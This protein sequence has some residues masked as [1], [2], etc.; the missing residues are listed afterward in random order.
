MEAEVGIMMSAKDTPMVLF[1]KVIFWFIA[2]NALVGAM[3][4][5]LFPNRT[6]A[7]FFWEITPPIN[8]AL[9]GALYLGGAATVAWVTYRGLW[10][11]ARFLVPILVSAG[12]FI[13]DGGL[14]RGGPSLPL[15]TRS[16]QATRSREFLRGAL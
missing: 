3:S 9:F 13:W 12:F 14:R 7:L 11:P 5:M 1:T 2:V 4:L 15:W 8:A 6:D 10:E 16:R